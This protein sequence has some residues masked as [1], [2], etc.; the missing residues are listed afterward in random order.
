V[1]GRQYDF[2]EEGFQ[3]GDGFVA[4]LVEE[5]GKVADD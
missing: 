3:Q 4:E 5:E 2:V 1:S